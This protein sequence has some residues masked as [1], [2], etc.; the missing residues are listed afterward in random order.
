VVLSISLHALRVFGGGDWN[1]EPNVDR[2]TERLWSWG[3]SPPVYYTKPLIMEALAE[4]QRRLFSLSS[5]R[6]APHRLAA[7]YHLIDLVPEGTLLPKS[8]LLCRVR[9]VNT[10]EAVWLN[11][12]PGEQG[13]VRLRW[14][15][16]KEQQEVP[17]TAVWWPIRYDVLPG[18]TYDF[19]IEISVPR[20]PGEY[21]L[22][23]GL[24]DMHIT[25]FA[26][27]GVPPLKI[28]YQVAHP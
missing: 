19:T 14:R 17:S 16:S 20:E 24:I 9:V 5:S 25:S 10:G 21:L 2:H 12:T 7:S 6:D 8:F 22:E 11:R 3:D 4:L 1:G 26:E 15:W 13:E 18:Q 27:Q 28:A 23:L